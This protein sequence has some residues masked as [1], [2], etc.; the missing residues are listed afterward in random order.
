MSRVCERT[1]GRSFCIRGVG[2]HSGEDVAAT[3]S[4]APDGFGIQFAPSSGVASSPVRWAVENVQCSYLATTIGCSDWRIMTAEHLVAALTGLEVDNA[5]IEVDGP[6][7]PILDGSSRDWVNAI[8]KVGTKTGQRPRQCLVVSRVVEVQDGASWARLEPSD[9][10]SYTVS[11]DFSHPS[12]GQQSFELRATPDHFE[13]HVSWARTFGF[14]EDVEQLRSVGRGLGGSLK[15]V[16]VFG[17]DGPLN[18]E[19][20]RS[21]D[22][23]VRHKVLDMVGDIALAGSAV[24]GR[25]LAHRPSHALTRRLLEEAHRV[26][27][28]VGTSK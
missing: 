9:A 12:I 27:A 24:L 28:L 6:E 5:L 14:L 11:V 20:L 1:L 21:I 19:G 3:V 18:P 2:L 8:K 25:V 13:R 15:N 7:V 22:E 17:P 10:A 26:E 16:V 4:P 23:V